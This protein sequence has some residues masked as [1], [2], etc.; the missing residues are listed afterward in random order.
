MVTIPENLTQSTADELYTMLDELAEY[1]RTDGRGRDE[2]TAYVR[3]FC[4]TCRAE[5]KAEIKRRGLPGTKPGDTRV[6]G[7]GMAAW[8]QA[9]IGG[10]R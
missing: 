7:P 9:G 8:Q 6:Y 5:I 4:K 10:A 3:D 1:R 2:Y